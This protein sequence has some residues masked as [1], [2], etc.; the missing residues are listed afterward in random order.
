M[1]SDPLAAM[2]LVGMGLRDLSIE[3]AA[4]AEIKESLRRA[5]LAE[6]EA[7]AREVLAAETA[8]D[9]ER[10]VAETF[11]PRLSDVLAAED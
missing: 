6:C 9:V 7:L 4:I 10:I 5:T 3:A 1:A 11:A 2:L 8:A